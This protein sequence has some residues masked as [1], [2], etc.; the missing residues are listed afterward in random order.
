MKVILIVVA[1]LVVLLI[2]RS[3]YK[4]YKRSML[5][6]I[7]KEDVATVIKKEYDDG[8]MMRLVGRAWVPV[9]WEEFNIYVIYKGEKFCFD[10]EELYDSVEAG[11]EVP[12]VVH[13][14]YDESRKLKEMYIDLE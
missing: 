12:I 14:A 6:W 11:D 9:F 13:K 1:L 5:R 8:V 3:L 4:S 10:N 2:I 7:R